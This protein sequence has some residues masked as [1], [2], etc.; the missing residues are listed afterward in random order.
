MSDVILDHS[1]LK[2]PFKKLFGS[3]INLVSSSLSYTISLFPLVLDFF[4]SQVTVQNH[5]SRYM[6]LTHY[7]VLKCEC[8]VY[9]KISMNPKNNCSH[10][11]FKFNVFFLITAIYK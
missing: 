3:T 7:F 2:L 6:M 11:I 1:Q 9:S 10:F 5:T 4:K 8:F